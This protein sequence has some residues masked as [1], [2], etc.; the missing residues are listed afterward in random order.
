MASGAGRTYAARALGYGI[1]ALR[2]DG[3]D[4]LAVAAVSD[5][6]VR[7]ARAGLGPAFV[8]W[9]TYRAAAH[10]TSDNPAAYR[11]KDEAKAWPLGDPIARLKGHLI[12]RGLWSEDRH[13]QAEAQVLDEVMQVQKRVEAEGTLLS[14]RAFPPTELFEGVYAEMPPHLMRQRAEM[15]E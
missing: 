9:F 3:N 7:R 4:Y 5:W 8:E 15:G 13:R 6:A 11:P 1:P 2:V 14:P 10:S 12:T